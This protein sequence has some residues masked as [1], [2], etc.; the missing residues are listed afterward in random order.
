MCN[1]LHVIFL[2]AMGKKR[3]CGMR[4]WQRVKSGSIKCGTWL[5]RLSVDMIVMQTTYH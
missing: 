1:V 5:R 4:K 3:E 2:A